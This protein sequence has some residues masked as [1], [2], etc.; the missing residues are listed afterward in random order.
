MS[1]Q[2]NHVG[3]IV[4][5]ADTAS[6]ETMLEAAI[7]VGAD[8]CLSDDFAHEF[9]C[10]PD[11]FYEVR[12][13]LESQFGPPESAALVWIPTSTVALDEDK[14]STLFKMIEALEESD[15][16]QNV[17]ANFDVADEIIDRLSA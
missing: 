16:V 6:S 7:N 14:A 13:A 1:F 12:E 11:S 3:Q 15:D 17:S 5:L 8:D 9:L 10:Q 4:Y 2:F